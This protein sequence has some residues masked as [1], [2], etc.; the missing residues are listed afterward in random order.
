[1][2]APVELTQRTTMS[3]GNSGGK[4]VWVPAPAVQ[5]TS[6]STGVGVAVGV[7]VS[8]PVAAGVLVGVIV[9]VAVAVAV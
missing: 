3:P 2:S 6:G 4:V 1:V 8:V 7:L 5:P 9:A